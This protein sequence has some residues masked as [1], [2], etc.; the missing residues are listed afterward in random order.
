MK[1]TVK[2]I[3]NQPS[4]VIR[5]DSVELA[6]TQLGGHMAP[7]TFFRDSRKPCQPYYISPWQKEK[8]KTGVP[9]LEPLRGDFFCLPFGGNNTV[10]GESHPV[11]GETAT[12]KWTLAGVERSGDVT[13]LELRMELTIRPGRAMKTLSLVAGQNVVYGRDVIEGFAGP[14]TMGHHAT[15]AMPEQAQSVKV[16]TTRSASD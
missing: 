11:H 7:V 15:L 13:S 5:S 16:T 3:V 1:P 9:I 4:W 8:I 12:K 6:V 10:A 2:T 14:T